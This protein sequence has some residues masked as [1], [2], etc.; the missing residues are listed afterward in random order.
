[1]SKRLCKYIA[2]FYY[3]DKSLIVLFAINGAVS[4][5][6]FTTVTGAPVGIAGPSYNL[7]NQ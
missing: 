4:I 1:M 5:T 7:H 6:P 3:F 2:S